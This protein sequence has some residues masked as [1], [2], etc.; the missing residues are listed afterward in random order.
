[1]DDYTDAIVKLRVLMLSTQ[2]IQPIGVTLLRH[3]AQHLEDQLYRFVT[4]RDVE[5]P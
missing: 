4:G 3:A 1:M 5:E 2:G